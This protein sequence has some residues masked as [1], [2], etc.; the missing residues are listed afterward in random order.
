M[1]QSLSAVYLHLVFSTKDRRPFLNDSSLRAEMHAY[2]AGASKQLDCPP[3]LAGGVSDHVHLLARHGR[4]ITQAD[5]VKELKRVSTIWIKGR[6][7]TMHDFGWQSGY[8]VF[9]VSPSNL[10]AVREYIAGQEE[11]HRKSSFQDEFRTLLRKHGMEWNE[12]YVWD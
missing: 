11:H 6:D 10:D 5:W 1:P 3:V 9:S 12:R 7:A 2:L 8:G 4:S